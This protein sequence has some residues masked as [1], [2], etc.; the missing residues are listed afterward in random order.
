LLKLRQVWLIN[1]MQAMAYAARY[2][3][4]DDLV[5][6]NT[7]TPAPHG[8]IAVI[9]AGTGLGEGFL[10][11]DGTRYRAIASEGGHS[12][13]APRADIEIALLR[14]LLTQHK[15]VSYERVV[16]GQG[17]SAIYRFLHRHSGTPEP[18]WFADGTAPSDPAVA[19]SEAAM[20]GKD[21]LAVRT[22]AMFVS[23]YGAEAGNLALKVLATGGVFIGG[24]IAPKILP[25]L[26]SG[27][28]LESFFRK[29]RYE[30]LLRAM[31]VSIMTSE[32]SALFGAAHY[33]ELMDG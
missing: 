18:G 4:N 33:A 31:P 24:G 22:L 15:R 23:L 11:W 28:F 1:D 9:A 21:E 20:G 26:R 16:S 25:V 7:G 2:S 17:L 12:D 8:T 19:I 29:G 14:F 27:A 13:F 32:K 6:L 3:R 30:Q 10:V 5:V